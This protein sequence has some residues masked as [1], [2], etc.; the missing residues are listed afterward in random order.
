MNPLGPSGRF[1]EG[2]D[3]P[4]LQDAKALLDDGKDYSQPRLVQSP[5]QA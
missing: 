3:T 2:L 1:T 5:L 4:R